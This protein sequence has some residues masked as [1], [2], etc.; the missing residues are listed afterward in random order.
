[1]RSSPVPTLALAL[2]ATILVFV[3]SRAVPAQ[4]DITGGK[5]VATKPSTPP[6]KKTTPKPGK[7]RVREAPPKTVVLTRNTGALTVIAEPKAVVTVENLANGDVEEATVPDNEQAF[8]FNDLP[9]GR[10]NVSASLAGHRPAEQ[11]S[12]VKRGKSDKVELKLEPITHNVTVT[13]NASSG[14]LKYSRGNED[15]DVKPF[16]GGSLVLSGLRPGKYDVEFSPDDPTY[17][18]LRAGVVVPM[19]GD[20]LYLK[21]ERKL[22]EKE[23]SWASSADWSLPAGWSVNSKRRLLVVD[24]RGLALPSDDSFRHYQDFKISSQVRM[25]NG[26]AV[27]FV[28]RARDEK[29]Y[30]LVQ[31]TGGNAAERYVLRGYIVENGGA[32]AFGRATPISQFAETIKPDK[33]F[34]LTLTMTGNDIDVRAEDNETGDLLPLG[35]LSD[36]SR[37]F[38]IGGVGLVARDNEKVEVEQFIIQPISKPGNRAAN[39]N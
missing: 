19:P 25:T 8:I 28:L 30:Y 13:S 12:E 17:V 32:R 38:P 31:L 2:F 22:S 6:P 21:L 5:G 29:N 23:F 27:S 7:R 4:N 3:L 1:M 18:P 14:M 11:V 20:S 39:S 15:S 10:Y 16:E 35:K 34:R 37:T 26:V 9:P 24:G 33:F 36:P